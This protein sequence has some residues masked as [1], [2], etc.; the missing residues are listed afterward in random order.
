MPH[1]PKTMIG[2]FHSFTTK[3]LLTSACAVILSGGINSFLQG[4]VATFAP[5]FPG[6]IFSL[7]QILGA[8]LCL[9]WIN[10]NGQ[11]EVGK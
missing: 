2:D 1:Q 6:W 7:I 5:L 8:S 10:R 4:L 11:K 9:W 3:L